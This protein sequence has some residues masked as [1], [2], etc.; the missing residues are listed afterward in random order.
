MS[1]LKIWWL[2][3]LISWHRVNLHRLTLEKIETEIEIDRCRFDKH[4]L[5][6]RLRNIEL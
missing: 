2:K 6:Y 1:K 4:R 5:E 3:L